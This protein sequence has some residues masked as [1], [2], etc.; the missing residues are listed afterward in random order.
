MKIAL[1]GE[2]L[3]SHLD[4]GLSLSSAER[5]VLP[6]IFEMLVKQTIDGKIEPELAESYEV[7]KNKIIFD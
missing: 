1:H 3:I 5:Q 7:Q 4:P 2:G 6:Q